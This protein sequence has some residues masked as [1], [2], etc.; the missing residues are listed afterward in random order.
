MV[1]MLLS[2]ISR[3]VLSLTSV[4]NTFFIRLLCR[5]SN[6]DLVHIATPC[7]SFPGARRGKPCAPGGPLRIKAQ[8]MG[9]SFFSSLFDANKVKLGSMMLARTLTIIKLCETKSI[10]CTLENPE[11]SRSWWSPGTLRTLTHGTKLR[12]DY[13]GFS[14]RWKKPSVFAAW[15]LPSLNEFP[16]RCHGLRHNNGDWCC[17]FSRKR[18]IRLQGNA[19]G[20]ALWTQVAEPYPK[21]L[22]QKYAKLVTQFKSPP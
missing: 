3:M 20:G 14:T 12:L 10:S 15:H 2:G 19:P 1:G 4:L 22:C 13:C 17:E 11:C 6:A 18:H 5:I 9:I 7:G 8:P 21:S 16:V